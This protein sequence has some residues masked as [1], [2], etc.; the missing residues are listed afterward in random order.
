[1]RERVR[2]G[3]EEREERRRGG[4]EREGEKGRGGERGE[5][6]GREGER[7]EKGRERRR[8][9]LGTVTIISFHDVTAMQDM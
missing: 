4:N 7:A 1:M 3:E 9:A 8:G 6:K 5:E 2:R